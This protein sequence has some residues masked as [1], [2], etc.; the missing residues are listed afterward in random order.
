LAEKPLPQLPVQ[1]AKVYAPADR[2]IYCGSKENL[3]K[4]HIIPFSLGGTWTFPKASCN[5]CAKIT[6]AF[7]GEFCR[8]ILGPLRMLFNLPTRRPKERPKHLPLKVK[9]ATSTDWEMAYVD[10]SICPF[11]IGMPLY[12]LPSVLTGVHDE[13]SK[14]AATKQLWLRGGG[15]WPDRDKHL[16][17]LCD[18]LRATEVM[19]SAEVP[20]EAICLSLA[21]IAHAYATAELGVD[22]FSPS[23]TNMIRNRDVSDRSKYIGGGEGNEA[24]VEEL[25]DV[26][27]AHDD[28]AS[29]LIVVK[30]R[31]LGI[32]G[33]PTY[34][35]VAG[36]PR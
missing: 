16:Q 5:A 23:L 20:T 6:G 34:T 15:F 2:C 19:P 29:Q 14:G 1:P 13:E 17:W 21:K 35:I 22:G 25:H 30:V 12:P 8:T 36:E 31:L 32:L 11:L 18:A 3:T 7:E 4:E 27:F 33:T 28:A 10:R 26:A 9:Y 24:P